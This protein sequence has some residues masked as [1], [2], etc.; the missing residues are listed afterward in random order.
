MRRGTRF[1]SWQVLLL[2]LLA[3]LWAPVPKPASAQTSRKTEERIP[4]VPAGY[5]IIDG[6]IQIPIG[7]VDSMRSQVQL[8]PDA[9]QAAFRNQLWPNGIIPFRFE[10]TCAATSGCIGAPLSGCV[11][12]ANQTSMLN[13]MAALEAVA[14]VD[15]QQGANNDCG[16]GNPT[17][18]LIRDSTN[19]RTAGPGNT[20]QDAS[21][22]NSP[23][24]RQG[25]GQ[26]VNIVS[27]TG[28]SSQFIMMHE[29]MHSLGL[30]HEQV[31]SDRDNYV[32]I[33]AFCN[34]VQGG[35]LGSTYLNNFPIQ[36]AAT[37]YGYYDFDSVMHYGQ[38]SFS[39][40]SNCPA[41][42]PAFP[43]GGITIQVKSPYNTQWQGAIGQRAH[44]SYLD[45]ITLSFLYPR[46][47]WRFVSQ[48]Y[49]GANGAPNGSFLRPFLDVPTGIANTPAEG[50]LWISPGAYAAVGAY[51]TQIPLQAPLG[52]V[53]LQ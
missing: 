25:G 15:F 10:T 30:F 5:T 48:A 14:N 44:L 26:I 46:S 49:N 27:W 17:H 24:G 19:D 20:C 40:N 31:R 2:C 33:A 50:T 7:D 4:G 13:A 6:D 21:A 23:V 39:R 37:A 22:N 1:T 43:D 34:N 52:G 9:P 16:G 41:V 32:N 35:C 8:K 18:I 29:L 47:N 11:S 38:C 53:R 3:C 42:S 28:A 45:R 51:N 36:S 12:A